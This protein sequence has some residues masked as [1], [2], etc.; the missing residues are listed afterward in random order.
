MTFDNPTLEEEK[1]LEAS[2]QNMLT[3]VREALAAI[4]PEKSN[5]IK[6]TYEHY[7]LLGGYNEGIYED[8]EAVFATFIEPLTSATSADELKSGGW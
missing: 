1:A 5:A 3:A 7:A 4:P 2:A 8:Y 6:E